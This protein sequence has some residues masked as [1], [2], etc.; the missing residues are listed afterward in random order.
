MLSQAHMQ[1]GQRCKNAVNVSQCKFCE[2]HVAGEY[3]KLQPTRGGFMDSM[4]STAFR[5]TPALQ[6]QRQRQGVCIV[7]RSAYTFPMTC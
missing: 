5:R 7:H 1:D 6:Q 4:L 2:F 3:R